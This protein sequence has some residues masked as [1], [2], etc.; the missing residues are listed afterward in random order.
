MYFLR[1]FKES[2]ENLIL[3]NLKDFKEILSNLKEILIL[4]KRHKS[5]KEVYV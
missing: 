3:R 4:G 1:N 2:Y 5:R